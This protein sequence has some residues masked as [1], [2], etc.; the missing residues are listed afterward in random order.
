MRHRSHGLGTIVLALSTLL[1][2][3]APAATPAPAVA[4][5]ADLDAAV[6]HF[7]SGMQGYNVLR[8][9]PFVEML[10]QEPAPFLLDVREL[11]EVEANGYIP[12]AV[13]IPLRD[14]AEPLD[15]ARPNPA[16]VLAVDAMLNGLP[17]GWGAITVEDLAADLAERPEV[18]LIDVRT[19]VEI[20]RNGSIIA[21]NALAIP[22]EELVARRAEW[23]A[24]SGASIV[25]Y[26]GSGHRGTI[27]MTIMRTYGYTGVRSLKGG[28]GAWGEAGHPIG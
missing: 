11:S 16:L 15:A 25:A 9:D 8:M 2:A 22:I 18:V 20:D 4:T 26:S 12:G 28:M 21:E 13:V 6:N 7:L 24:E 23:P 10:A 27:A 17:Q 3:C 19:Q 5:A 1:G 14:L